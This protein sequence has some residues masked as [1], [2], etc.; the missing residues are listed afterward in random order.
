MPKKIINDII[1]SRKS[2]RQIPLSEEKSTDYKKLK[3]KIT[4]SS[5]T[6][7]RKPL[8]P[9]FVIWLIAGLCVLALFFGISFLFSSATVIITP[10]TEK[11]LFNN[12]TY[13]AK[14]NST[15]NTDLSFEILKVTQTAGETV[16]ATEE[17]E[18][19]QKATGQIVIYNN[20]STA[21]QRLINNTRFEANNGKVYRINSSVVVPGLKKDSTGKV[22]PG[23]VEAVVYA[24]QAG[25]TY[26]LK[27][28]DLAGDFKIP[29]FKGDVRYNGFYARLKTDI[30]GGFIGKQRIVGDTLRKST[31]ESVKAKLKE[32]LL[33]E[34]YSIMPENYLIFKDGYSIDYMNQADTAVGS[35]KAKI[36]ISGTLNGIVFNNLKLSKYIGEKKVTNFDGLPTE[37]VV[38]D[39]LTVI[40]TGADSTGLYKNTSLQVRL[41]G[42][43]NIKWSY[44]TDTLKKDLAGKKKA[45]LKEL[46]SKYKNSV[47]G[48][49]VVFRPVWTRYFPDNLNKIK[50]E[51][52]AI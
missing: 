41:N 50:V 42:E 3:R 30:I 22:I 35:D 27:L 38:S 20:Y 12:D 2:I 37:L 5:V 25:D 32:Q 19:S 15:T 8:N 47:A 7:N 40:L 43:A 17:K 51:E 9:K 1:V 28:A 24:D 45:D 46:V 29:G 31:E 18:V 21:P 10:R 26:N 16:D 14:L 23:S 6:T 44:D 34:L 13:T 11:I 39:G 52:K 36:N 49:N 33:K 48:I 4:D